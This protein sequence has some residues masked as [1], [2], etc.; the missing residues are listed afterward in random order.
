MCPDH[1]TPRLS[2]DNWTPLPVFDWLQREGNI[3]T[4]EMRQTF[5]MGIGMVFA[6]AENDAA[7]VLTELEALG[8][9][10]VIIGDLTQ[11]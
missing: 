4:S 10:P 7:A 11:K 8:E 1:L 5:N 3:E 9:Q 2:F 6:V